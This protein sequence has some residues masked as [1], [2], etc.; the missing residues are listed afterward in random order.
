VDF[1]IG[2]TCSTPFAAAS[3]TSADTAVLPFVP[4]VVVPSGSGLH[5]HTFGG[6]IVDGYVFVYG[7]TI[8]S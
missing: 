8:P 3:M 7:Y 6:S 4:G 5:A 1:H 2:G